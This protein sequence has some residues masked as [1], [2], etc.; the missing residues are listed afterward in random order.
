MMAVRQNHTFVGGHA[1]VLIA[2]AIAV[3]AVTEAKADAVGITSEPLALDAWDPGRRAVGR[4]IHRGG[5]VLKSPDDRFGGLSAL[6]I[7]PDGAMMVAI[8]DDGYRIEAALLYDARGDLIGVADARLTPIV[9]LDGKPLR[10]KKTRDAESLASDGAGGW[11]IGFEQVHRLWRYPATGLPRALPTPLGLED[12][13]A[14]GGLEALTRLGDG[15]LLAISEKLRRDDVLVGWIGGETGWSSLGYVPDA[16]FDVSDAATL[17]DGNVM[18]LERSVGLLGG[19]AARLAT[20]PAGAIVPGA[21]LR[22]SEIAVLRS[23]INVDNFEG[24]DARRGERGKTLIYLVSDD[25]YSL[26]QRTLLVLFE[27]AP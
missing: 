8:S 14:N 23:P 7:S 5:V 3:L 17:P 6:R 2:A 13:P 25:N 15:R 16:G 10:G 24:V 12:A 21:R 20:V 11:V 18:V 27:L 26:L 22:G 4:L 1:G 9:R 19:Y